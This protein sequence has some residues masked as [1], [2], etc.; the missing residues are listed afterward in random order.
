MTEIATIGHNQP[1]APTPFELARDEVEE[2]YAEAEGWLDGVAIETKGQADGISTLI[3]LIRDARKKAD[4]ARKTENDPFDKGKAEVQ[5]RYNPLLKRCDLAVDACKRALE[6][7]LRKEA[8]AKEAA[9]AEARRIADE[10]AKAAQEAIRKADL[11][12]L[13]AREVAE[14]LVKD[15]KKAETDANRAVRDTAKAGMGV[16]RATSLRSVW[17]PVMTDPV[18][19]IRHYWVADQQAITT[20]LMTLANADV[21]NGKREIPGFSVVEK[22]VVV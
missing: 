1:P 12:N 14:K 21:R 20:F 10:K 17:T 13:A 6:P 18:A 22:R 7:W 15:A 4:E 19:A 11:D 3:N 5:A 16:G 9:A 2:L 8:D